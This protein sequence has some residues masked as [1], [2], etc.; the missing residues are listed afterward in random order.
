MKEPGQVDVLV[1]GAGPVG[2]ACALEAARQGLSHVVIEKEAP[3]QT[4]VRWPTHTVFFSTP[5]LLEI[6]GHPFVTAGGKPTRREGLF[7]YRRVAESEGI[8]IRHHEKVTS[9]KR[10]G[11]FFRVA[12]AKGLHRA[13]AVVVATGFFD[14][15]NLIGVPG[16][17]LPKVSHYYTE[18]FAHTGSD[19]LVVGG[20]NS[21]VE[22]ALDLHRNGARVTMAVRG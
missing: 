18:P 9:L 17:D 10:E 21:A 22:A 8:V 20:K 6:G 13:R 19:V 11:G 5:E 14:T 16:E 7:Y 4:L 1:I 2:L 15:P 3:L 12:T